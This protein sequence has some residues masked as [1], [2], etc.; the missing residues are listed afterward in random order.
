MFLLVILLSL[1]IIIKWF[2]CMTAY[3]VVMDPEIGIGAEKNPVA[4]FLMKKFGV[5][6]TIVLIM[7]IHAAIMMWA[8]LLAVAV[9][10]W[11][12]YSI[13]NIILFLVVINNLR[14]MY[15]NKI[16][17]KRLIGDIR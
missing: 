16:S 2:E 6:Q 8:S 5:V 11:M 7:G 9:N 3:V 17:F 1:S 10:G 14:V 15:K 12:L 13:V 4:K